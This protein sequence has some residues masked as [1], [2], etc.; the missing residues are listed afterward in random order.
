MIRANVL[1]DQV[2]AISC[3]I[4]KGKAV[5]DLDYVEIPKPTRTPISS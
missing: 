3:G 5:L 2:A 1:K 4:Y